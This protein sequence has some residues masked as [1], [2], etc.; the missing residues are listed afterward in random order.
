MTIATILIAIALL[1]AVL[2]MILPNYH[3]LPVA[4]IFVCVVL[5]IGAR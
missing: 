5:L 1:M 3:L 4:V 2:S